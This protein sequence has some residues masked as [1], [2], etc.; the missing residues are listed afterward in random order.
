MNIKLPGETIRPTV[1]RQKLS[2]VGQPRKSVKK[3]ENIQF[4]LPYGIF[5]LGYPHLCLSLFVLGVGW[6]DGKCSDVAVSALHFH[7]MISQ[8]ISQLEGC[9]F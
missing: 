9:W 2:I 6:G 8:K 3:I 5:T 1:L 4:P 7:Q